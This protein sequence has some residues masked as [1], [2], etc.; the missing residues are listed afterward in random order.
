[1]ANKEP[2]V[3]HFSRILNKRLLLLWACVCAAKLKRIWF[4]DLSQPVCCCSHL[5]FGILPHTA[6]KRIC[7]H[8]SENFPTDKTQCERFI[9]QQQPQQT[10]PAICGRVCWFWSGV[11]GI[12]EEWSRLLGCGN[13]TGKAKQSK[14]KVWLHSWSSQPIRRSSVGISEAACGHDLR[15]LMQLDKTNQKQSKTGLLPLHYHNVELFHT[16]I[17]QKQFNIQRVKSKNEKPNQE[18]FSFLL[19]WSQETVNTLSVLHHANNFSISQVSE[20]SQLSWFETIVVGV[21]LF[22]EVF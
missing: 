19:Q 6:R 17:K 9:M 8:G 2:R 10:D 20:S 14:A 18:S 13:I 21:H 15:L 12:L 4:A 11:S 5:L 1:M 16:V 7:C 3:F 22:Q